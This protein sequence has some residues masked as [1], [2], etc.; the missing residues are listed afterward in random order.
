M[1]KPIFST[2]SSA[3]SAPARPETQK[4]IKP[5]ARHL[6]TEYRRFQKSVNFS[7]KR[8]KM[9]RMSHIEPWKIKELADALEQFAGG[10]KAF[11]EPEWA[12]V[13][14]H[15][16]AECR[17]FLSA[18]RASPTGK[19][20]MK[21]LVANVRSCFTGSATLKDVVMRAELSGDKMEISRDLVRAKEYLLDLLGELERQTVE[22]VH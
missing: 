7:L 5:G 18:D 12:Q 16:E 22:F 2:S 10:L 14:S 9:A 21:V 19:R 20:E 11:Q 8:A 4:N 1:F 6:N 3:H 15:Y 13:F 17:R